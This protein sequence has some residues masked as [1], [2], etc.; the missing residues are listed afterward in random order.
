[1][2]IDLDKNYTGGI[3]DPAE[4]PYSVG[5]TADLYAVGGDITPEMLMQAYPLGIFPWFDFKRRQR[6]LWFCPRRRFV[7]FPDEIHVSHS[8][9]TLINSGRYRVTVNQD[10]AGVIN[11]CAALRLDQE[12]AWLG[13]EMVAAYTRLHEMDHAT[14]IEVWEGNRLVGG[15]YGVEMAGAFFGESMF[16]MVPSASKLALIHLCREYLPA[17]GLAF[18]DCQFHTLHLESM[19]GRYIPYKKFR[20]LLR[21]Q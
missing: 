19:G 2:Y 12:G 4:P 7:L 6:P 20:S 14:S 17:R 8:M 10:F 16:S 15:L 5:C 18:V 9:R 13:P 11:G 3:P 21:P 1:M